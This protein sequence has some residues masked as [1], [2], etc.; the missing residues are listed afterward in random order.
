MQSADGGDVRPITPEGAGAAWAVA[1]DG[2]RVAA[3]DADRRLLLYSVDGGDPRPIPGAQPGDVPV[4]F[5]PDGRAL[6]VLVRGD[7]PRAEIHRVDLTTGERQLWKEVAPADP[8]GV[9]GVP[10]VF[11]SADG[12]SYVYSYVRML[13]ELYLVDGLR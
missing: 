1:P 8:I 12:Q 13:D 10:R 5:T 2:T 11:L 4:R 7:G 9:Y 3:S 6:Y